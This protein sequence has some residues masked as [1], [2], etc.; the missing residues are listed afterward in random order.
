MIAP[1]IRA[2]T[3]VLGG[4]LTAGC[5]QAARV[6]LDIPEPSQSAS[7]ESEVVGADMLDSIMAM[8]SAEPDFPPT[9]LEAI[10]NEDSIL[11]LLPRDLAGSVDWVA[12]VEQDLIRPRAAP[13]GEINTDSAT[14]FPFD[15]YLGEAEGPEAFFPH[16]IHTQWASC[17]SCHPGVYRSRSQASSVSETHESASCSTCHNGIAFPIQA[18]ERCHASATGLP[19]ARLEPSLGPT[20]QMTR[21][22]VTPGENGN[23]DLSA[24]GQQYYPAATFPHGKHR[25]RFQCRACHEAP[26]PMQRGATLMGQQEAHGPDGCGYCHNSRSA[27]DIGAQDCHRCHLER[28]RGEGEGS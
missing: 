22:T 16:S 8:L 10:S 6:F 4:M 28:Q 21:V 17:Q 11:A 13:R 27:F 20:F 9:P 2:L 25:I 12:A 15:F 14:F 26:F 7:V 5:M 1:R 24:L 23:G 18:C 3:L 19:S